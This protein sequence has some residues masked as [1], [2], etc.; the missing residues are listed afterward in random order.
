MIQ[1]PYITV[2]TPTYNRAYI[3]SKLYNSLVQ[4]TYTN[5][6]WL[7]IDD[8]SSDNTE[9]IIHSFIDEQKILIRYYKQANGGKHRAIN[10]ASQLAQGEL[11]FI[12]DS[13]DYL[14]DIALERIKVYY[15]TV[16]EM[17]KYAGVCG[18]KCYPDGK[19]IGGEL[20]W[21]IL[22]ASWI[23]YWIQKKIKGDVAFA[24]RTD[25]MRQ[26]QFPD[27]IG[28]KFCAES[29]ILNRIGQKYKL[30]FFNE[31]ICVCEYLTDGLS[32]SSINNRMHSPSYA[33]LIYQEKAK[34]NISIKERSI[35]YI[36]YWRFAFCSQESF[37][38]K[39]KQ[40]GY[41]SFFAWPFGLFLHLKD[42][43]FNKINIKHL[44]K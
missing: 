15:D 23:Q 16:V 19:R 1:T 4:Q 34:L 39:I 9:S 25:I 38:Q 22:D 3:I 36:N 40:I 27:I 30:R 28:E 42:Q 21:S 8:G 11:F 41:I 43:L 29:L 33:M 32:A 7:V 5:F 24:F 6:E 37:Y 10:Y 35:A 44:N 18:M 17:P 12:V 2:F 26:Y 31:N 20:S 13:D 14:L